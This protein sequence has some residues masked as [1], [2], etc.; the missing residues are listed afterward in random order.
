MLS[1]GFMLLCSA[2]ETH[3]GDLRCPRLCLDVKGAVTALRPLVTA[4]CGSIEHELHGES[5]E[6]CKVIQASK[7]T[8]GVN[9]ET[10]EYP[11]PPPHSNAKT[12]AGPEFTRYSGTKA[13]Y[14]DKEIRIPVN[15]VILVRQSSFMSK[16]TIT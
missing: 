5:L 6:T 16:F 8:T 10:R 2:I 4:G 12:S 14:V 13:T 3:G 11:R 15:I 9:V 1:Q 7:A